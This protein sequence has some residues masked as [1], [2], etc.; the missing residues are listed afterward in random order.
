MLEQGI[1]CHK[2]S[3]YWV[4]VKQLIQRKFKKWRMVVDYCKLNDITIND[5]NYVL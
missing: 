1:I 5:S 3:P 4:V 2:S